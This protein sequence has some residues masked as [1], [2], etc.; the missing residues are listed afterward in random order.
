MDWLALG[1]A[2]PLGQFVTLHGV[3]VED[4]ASEFRDEWQFRV[5]VVRG[6]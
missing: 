5:R 4:F 2:Y 1:S 6:V 3:Q